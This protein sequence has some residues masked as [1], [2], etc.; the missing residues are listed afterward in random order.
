MKINLNVSY[1]Q[2][3]RKN[4][5]MKTDEI[6]GMNVEVEAACPAFTAFFAAAFAI[7]VRSLVFGLLNIIFIKF[8]KI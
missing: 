7:I 3:T 2:Y 1:F 5:K 8:I 6:S 4:K